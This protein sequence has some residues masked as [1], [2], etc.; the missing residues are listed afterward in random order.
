MVEI[1]YDIYIKSYFY[2]ILI[3]FFYLNAVIRDLKIL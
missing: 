2:N 3:T 1:F